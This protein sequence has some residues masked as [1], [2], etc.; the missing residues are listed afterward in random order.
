MITEEIENFYILEDILSIDTNVEI[1]NTIDI[2]VEDDESYVLASGIV[3]HNSAMG[4]LLQKR[5][6]KIDAAY[7]LKGKIKNARKL[8]DLT[9][10]AEI[11]DLM[12][13]LNLDPENDRACKFL[14]VVIATDADP[15]GHHIA[16]LIIQLFH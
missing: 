1:I 4:S 3:S 12:N 8:S 16:S 7:A 11:I 6:P 5:D 15:D 9:S 10:N 14:R 13:I 2:S